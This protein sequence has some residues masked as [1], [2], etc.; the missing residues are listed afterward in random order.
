MIRVHFVTLGCAKNEVDTRNMEERVGSAGMLVVDSPQQ[1]DAIVVNTCSFIQAATEESLEAV[2]DLAE[3]ESVVRGDAQIF[4]AGCMPSRYGEDLSRELKEARAFIPCDKEGD[5]AD[6]I[7]RCLSLDRG[8]S[9]LE[10]GKPRSSTSP[11]FA[12]YVKISDGCDRY[13]SYCTIPYIRGG[14]RSFE[15]GVLH[16]QVASLVAGGVREITLIAQDTGRWGEDLAAPS[17]LAWLLDEL[18]GTFGSTWF[19]VM[20][21]QP[22]GITDELLEVMSRHKNICKYFDIPLQHANRDILADMNRTGSAEEFLTLLARIRSAVPGATLR[23]TL[24]AGFPGESAEAFDELCAF[25]EEASF[26][27]VGVF[28]YSCEEGTRAAALPNQVDD[29]V[30]TERAQTIR[31][32]GDSLGPQRLEDRVGQE[33]EVLVLGFEEDGQLV[34]RAQCQAPEVDGVCYLS[35]GK[36]GELVKATVSDTLFYDMECE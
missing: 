20:Y 27:Y 35:Q 26:D 12:A 10:Q 32:L 7:M 34:G 9:G 5:I 16:A 33:I 18:A 15:A 24:I 4:V 2:L 23:T 31:D 1:A 30:K 14:Y 11:G 8:D 3:I 36:P 28:P 17:C 19:R 21:L 13:C 25:V 29:E 22:E 6:I